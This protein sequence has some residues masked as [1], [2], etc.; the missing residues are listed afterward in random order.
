MAHSPRRVKPAIKLSLALSPPVSQAPVPPV[1][2]GVPSSIT[3]C[4]PVSPGP[5][6]SPSR[7]L[8]NAKQ[9][10]L[11]VPSSGSGRHSPAPPLSEAQVP[12]GLDI[13]ETRSLPS[14]PRLANHTVNGTNDS[15]DEMLDPE[16]RG[17]LASALK[18]TMTMKRRTSLPRLSIAATRSLAIPMQEQSKATDIP[19]TPSIEGSRGLP[20]PLTVENLVARN[21]EAGAPIAANSAEAHEEFP[22]QH[23][24]KEILPGLYLGSEQNAKDPAILQA[25][26]ISAVLCVAKEVT[27]PWLQDL[28]CPDIPEADEDELKDSSSSSQA[29]DSEREPDLCYTIR[30]TA[31]LPS[32]HIPAT[33]VE[34]LQ[35]PRGSPSRPFLIRSSAST[36]NLQQDFRET[37]TN[38]AEIDHQR[39]ASHYAAAS[40]TPIRISSPHPGYLYKTFAANRSTGRPALSYT[41]LPWGHDEDDIATHFSTYNICDLIDRARADGGRCLVHCQLGVSR[42]ATLMIG[43]CMRQACLG[44]EEALTDVKTMHETYSYVRAK[45]RWV[46][47]N[48]GL[49]VRPLS[50]YHGDGF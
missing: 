6:F 38:A 28:D 19:P 31:Q 41:K 22:Y 45:S 27:C 46:A 21:R 4:T 7:K 10:S 32:L 29:S 25:F 50:P 12:T 40:D 24:P 15:V 1:V 39:P 30:R 20:L 26:G 13:T 42:S 3:C 35:P 5:A 18:G 48:I 9:L 33:A 49:L 23:G 43:Y 2:V 44:K 17:E 11:F 36:P 34:S 14:T 16:C 47:P 37:T 8:R